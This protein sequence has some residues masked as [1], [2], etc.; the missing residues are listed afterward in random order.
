MSVQRVS[1]TTAAVIAAIFAALAVRHSVLVATISDG[2]GYVSEAALWLSGHLFVPQPFAFWPAWPPHVTTP[3]GY[4][5]GPISGT[6]A[7]IYPPG[8]PL[9]LATAMAFGGE[10]AAYLVPPAMAGVLVW[11]AGDLAHRLAGEGA[12]IMAAALVA[13][14]AVTYVGATQPMSDVPA[15]AWWALAVAFGA[16][17]AALS[18]VAA[19]LAVAMAVLTRPNLA[20]LAVV[21]VALVATAATAHRL[22]HVGL[23]SGAA[24]TGPLLLLWIQNEMYGSPLSSGYPDIGQL[25]ALSN[26]GP[27]AVT[28]VRWYSQAHTWLVLV[29]F[30]APFIAWPPVNPDSPGVGASRRCLSLA[31]VTIVVGVYL[32][33]LPYAQWQDWYFVRFMLPALGPLY[34]LTAAVV[35]RMGR[36]V[37]RGAG[38]AAT[39]V[40][41]AV[42]VGG[43]VK[44]T[45][46]HALTIERAGNDRVLL[47][48]RYLDAA[49]PPNAI[50][51]TAYH[52][53]SVRHYT[54]RPILRG[55]LVPSADLDA[56][57]AR[58][59][60]SGYHPYLLLD[61]WLE[62]GGY[63]SL[64][65]SSRFGS[66]DWP[67]RAVIGSQGRIRLYDPADRDRYARGERWAIDTVRGIA[68]HE[69]Q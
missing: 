35:V 29:A 20:P 12:R 5:L 14:S 36:L 51:F 53:G 52:S 46:A 40:A 58:L 7:F 62:L 56:M 19:G 64:F 47:A 25:F 60:Q 21:P 69:E 48:G 57:L 28:Y 50:V 15:A 27:N 37:P 18:S 33:Y 63:Q 31:L 10:L 34:A 67:P 4:R 59:E 17:G 68:R 9:L 39:I 54:G 30:A 11:T 23:C 3:L 38:T 55:D 6:E 8:L 13:T 44:A 24:L 41:I 65:K 43:Q 66:L 42:A 2:S 61:D 32:A 45:Y 1:R 16:R 49:L 26:V 22:K